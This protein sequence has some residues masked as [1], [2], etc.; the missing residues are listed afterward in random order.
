MAGDP[1]GPFNLVNGRF[2]N[3]LGGVTL[4]LLAKRIA[5]WLAL[6]AACALAMF[7]LFNVVF[8]WG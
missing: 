2:E 1:R 5:L 3:E 6:G 7:A 8:Y 4:H